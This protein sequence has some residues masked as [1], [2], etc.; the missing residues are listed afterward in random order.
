MQTWKEGVGVVLFFL[1]EKIAH[2]Q[3]SNDP[4]DLFQSWLVYTVNNNSYCP[5]AYTLMMVGHFL[6]MLLLGYN[7]EDAQQLSASKDFGLL[8]SQ[9]LN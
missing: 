7:A 2:S 8:C 9:N 1:P 3:D 4:D 6:P 5:P